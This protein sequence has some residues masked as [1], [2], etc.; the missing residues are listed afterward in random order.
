M[1]LGTWFVIGIA[2][3]VALW[4]ATS[5]AVYLGV[6]IAIGIALDMATARR[7]D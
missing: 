2:I 1:N 5:N 7:K 4:A 6:G 3:G